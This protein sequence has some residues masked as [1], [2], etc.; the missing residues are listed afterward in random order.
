MEQGTISKAPTET[1]SERRRRCDGVDVTSA[2]AGLMAAR[3]AALAAGSGVEFWRCAIRRARLGPARTSPLCLG[4][5]PRASRVPRIA[6]KRSTVSQQVAWGLQRGGNV[7]GVTCTH[8]LANSTCRRAHCRDAA[9]KVPFWD[10]LVLASF[11]DQPP[12]AYGF[13]LLRLRR[14]KYTLAPN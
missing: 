9:Q 13:G 2:K 10:G 11:V 3:P 4:P 6:K 14:R 7:P 5:A 8:A 12:C 1:E